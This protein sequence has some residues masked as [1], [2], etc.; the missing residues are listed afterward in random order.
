MGS[1]WHVISSVLVLLGSLGIFLFGMKLMS[2]SLQKAAGHKMRTILAGLT[3]S[4][5]KGIFTGFLVTSVIQSSSATTVMIVSFVNAGLLTLVGAVG[6]IMGA[7]IGTTVTAWLIALLGF[8]FSIS[9]IALII[10][11]ITFFLLFSK[12]NRRRSIGELIIGFT[13]LFLGLEL[14]KSAVPDIN[15]N[16]QIVQFLSAY[17]DMGYVSILLFVLIG[18]IL[19]VIIQSSSATM[20]LTLVMCYNGWIGLPIAAAMVLGENIGTT[21]TA[22]FAA[23]MANIEAKRAARSHFIFNII[24]VIWILL[25]FHPVLNLISDL[26]VKITGYDPRIQQNAKEV[27]PATLALF[28]SM[29][30]IVNSSLLV[31]FTPQIAKLVTWMVPGK[32]GEQ[33][34]VFKLTYIDKSLFAT[35]EISLMQTQKELTEFSK[36]IIRMF[37]FIN[38]LIFEQNS[39]K[40]YDN[41]INRIVKYEEITDKMEEEIATYLSY[42]AEGQLSHQSATEVRSIM[43]IIDDLES[44]ADV[45][46][47]MSKVVEDKN[48]M[49]Q[50]LSKQHLA[51]LATIRDLVEKAL[52]VMDA[53]LQNWEKADFVKS[54]EIEQAT[55]KCRNE[56][57]NKHLEELQN[58]VYEFKVGTFYIQLF[59]L[60]EKTGDYIFN[61]SEA[62][63]K[64]KMNINA[65]KY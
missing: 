31:W 34:D 24:G 10:T 38:S 12:N 23:L 55:N 19:T 20:A 57:K 62:I 43:N 14:L 27:L 32:K 16:P 17:T 48:A 1:F 2:D 39:Q 13:I 33:E 8:K 35:S 56:L 40:N 22:N 49:K 36:R 52:T 28:H 25:L 21:I 44:A 61:V 47:S 65:F 63:H 18:T 26:M 54:F 37:G 51:D 5:I 15:S 29:F 58:K 46:Y 41:L 53:N 11:G 6:V 59:T 45:M 64:S 7:N 9:K 4:R 60:Y 30:N 42:I 50:E 3:S